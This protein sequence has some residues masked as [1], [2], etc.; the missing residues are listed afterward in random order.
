MGKESPNK[1][2]LILLEIYLLELQAH[3]KILDL[4]PMEVEHIWF[5]KLSYCTVLN[6]E[7][8]VLMF[9]VKIGAFLGFGC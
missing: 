5:P 1:L 2:K 6:L 8:T 9:L 7:P 4:N 3:G